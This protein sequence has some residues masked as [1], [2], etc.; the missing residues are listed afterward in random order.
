M[1]DLA[2]LSAIGCLLGSTLLAAEAGAPAPAA[3]AAALSAAP[4]VAPAKSRLGINLA[5][6]ADWG[7]EF[8]FV[9]VLRLSRQW[10][11]Q[12]KGEKWGGGP[13]LE[14]DSSGWV[15]RLE[16]DGW[17]ETPVLTGGPAVAGDRLLI[18]TSSRLYC[19]GRKR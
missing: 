11:S 5:G 19:M 4:D 9:D 18:R 7:T 13:K 8:P 2:I 1:R 12:K 6:P 17:A 16:P 3:P 14:R 15:K 10:I